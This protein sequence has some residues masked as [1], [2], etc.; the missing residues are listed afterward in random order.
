MAAAKGMEGRGGGGGCRPC[1]SEFERVDG[2]EGVWLGPRARSMRRWP[3]ARAHQQRT[4][5]GVIL[6]SERAC[7]TMRCACWKLCC[8]SIC[9]WHVDVL[10]GR[11]CVCA[12]L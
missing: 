9:L 3:R 6:Q 1:V 11:V 12:H 5:A 4:R 2:G 10:G 8:V 7:E